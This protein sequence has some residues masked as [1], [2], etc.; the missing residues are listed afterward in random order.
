MTPFSKHNDA[1]SSD[2]DLDTSRPTATYIPTGPRSRTCSVALPASIIHNSKRKLDLR[3]AL[4]GSIGRALAVF[5][6]DEIVIFNDGDYGDSVSM[7]TPLSTSTKLTAFS[8]PGHF[9]GMILSYMETPPFLRSRLFPMHENLEKAGML[10]SLDLP[11]HLRANEWCEY[12][13][14]ITIRSA[15][16]GTYIDCGLAEPRLVRD[17][18]IPSK[19]RLTVRLDAEDGEE[20]MA[21]APSAPREEGGYYWGYQIRNAGSLSAVFTECAFEGGYDLSIGTSERG[22]EVTGV[23]NGILNDESRRQWQ[24]MVVV[25]GGVKG[26]EEAAK[27]DEELV[28]IGVGKATVKELFDYW[29]NLIPGQGSRTIRTEEAL[30]MGLMATRRIVYEGM[31]NTLK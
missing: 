30:W 8:H 2:N 11:S 17:V 1:P 5:C 23:I 31:S 18:D 26:L 29:V 10:P 20:A 22:D 21:V 12:R 6:V 14:G 24:H 3:T 7:G 9:L 13:E 19:T 25:F 27:N 28:R 16:N 15:K 4:A